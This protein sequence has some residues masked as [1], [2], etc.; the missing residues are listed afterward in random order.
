MQANLIRL[1]QPRL[2]ITFSFNNNLF[3]LTKAVLLTILLDQSELPS[4]NPSEQGTL[5]QFLAILCILLGWQEASGSLQ[6]TISPF[7]GIELLVGNFFGGCD[8]ISPPPLLLGGTSSI[9]AETMIITSRLTKPCIL[10][11]LIY[12]SHLQTVH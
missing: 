6:W 9:L 4:V 11:S 1:Y 7:H 5:R 3:S 12:F 2:K 8:Y 10:P